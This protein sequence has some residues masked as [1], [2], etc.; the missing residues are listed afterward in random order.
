[1]K[2]T[3]LDHL[4]LTVTNIETTVDFYHHVLGMEKHTFA[5]NRVALKFGDQKINLHQAGQEFEPKAQKPT[6]GSVDL[7]F[8]TETPLPEAM[9][10][11]RGCG[12]EIIEGPVAR[13]GVM[14]PI[15]SFYFRDPDGNLIEVS[16]D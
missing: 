2:I 13:T 8:I 3:H 16:N 14:G 11:V 6:P 15:V 4:V 5:D 7:C 10:H 1:M 9:Q 12:I